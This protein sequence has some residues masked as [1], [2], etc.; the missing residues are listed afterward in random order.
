[1]GVDAVDA[2]ENTEKQIKSAGL[3]LKVGISVMTGVNDVKPEVFTLSDI[4]TVLNF[5]NEATHAYVARLSIWSMA[6][7]NGNC[8]GNT[9]ASDVCSGLKQSTNQFS[10]NFKT[11]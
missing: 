1:M 2:A 4:D 7:D 5:A 8:A 3:T 11:F 10:D 6:R 9:T